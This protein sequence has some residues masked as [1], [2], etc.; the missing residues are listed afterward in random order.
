MYLIDHKELKY[1]C[2]CRS[3]R[4]GNFLNKMMSYFNYFIFPWFDPLTREHMCIPAKRLKEKAYIRSSIAGLSHRLC[5]VYFYRCKK[6]PVFLSRP[7]TR[8]KKIRTPG[9]RWTCAFAHPY[10]HIMLTFMRHLGPFITK[11]E[12]D[13]LMF[14]W[15]ELSQHLASECPVPISIF[16]IIVAC[17]AEFAREK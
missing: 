14:L 17:V 9:Q 5:G 6:F 3:D 8:L 10:D 16:Q 4:V 2:S 12:E 11:S 15:C 7:S 13:E 1:R